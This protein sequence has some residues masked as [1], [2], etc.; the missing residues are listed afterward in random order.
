M[1]NQEIL[2][3]QRII[4]PFLPADENFSVLFGVPSL[5][6][7]FLLIHAPYVVFAWFFK[8]AHTSKDPQE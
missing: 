3:P 8:N 6:L 1:E 5:S 7:T 4:Y 2:S